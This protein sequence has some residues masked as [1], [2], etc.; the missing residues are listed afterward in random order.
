MLLRLLLAGILAAGLVYA[1][2][3]GGGEGGGTGSREPDAEAVMR[4]APTRLD[5]IASF[6]KLRSEQQ[7]QI[8]GAL[9]SIQKEAAPV[10]EEMAEKRAR[11]AAAVQA[12]QPRSEIDSAITAYATVAARMAGPRDEG[13]RR[14][15]PGPRPRPAHEPAPA[16]RDDERPLSRQKLERESV[17]ATRVGHGLTAT[18]S[19]R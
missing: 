4:S 10:R 6:L 16:F 8:R 5:I 2:R 12:G 3:G 11:I 13:F 7:K 14:H 18:E 15:L 19:V 17:P 9:D 1:Q